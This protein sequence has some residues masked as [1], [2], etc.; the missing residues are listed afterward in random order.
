MQK[1]GA[2]IP[3]RL[4]S[5]RLPGKAIM[6]ICGKPLVCHLID[7]VF[8]SRFIEKKNVVVC[9][10]E[11]VSDDPLA[12]IVEFYG[13]S[14]FRGS[15]DDIVKRFRDAMV[16]F[17]FDAVIQ[18]DGDDPLTD[19]QYMDLTMERL[20]ADPTVDI[21]SSSGL[22]LGVNSKSFTRAAMERVYQHYQTEE[23]DT[24]FIKFFTETGLCKHEVIEPL[25]PGHILDEARLTLDYQED[26]EVF[27]AIFEALYK[28]GEVFML[29]E[30]VTFLKSNPQIMAINS[31]LNEEYFKRHGEKSKFYY[32]DGEGKVLAV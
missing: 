18:V 26:F 30:L 25:G 2:L 27:K 7:R 10:T 11:D 9:T 16:A 13:A 19:P 23:N 14:V 1:I 12:E 3:V 21:V 29:S 32:R 5:E 8:A 20:L 15:R 24:G 22:P 6:E 4:G 17:D 31:S 28:E